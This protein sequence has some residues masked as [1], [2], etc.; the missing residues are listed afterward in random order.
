MMGASRDGAVLIFPAIQAHLLCAE[1]FP[2]VQ[3]SYEVRMCCVCLYSS[4]GQKI[5]SLHFA[6]CELSAASL[7]FR[8]CLSF[9]FFI[10][11]ETFTF[12]ISLF[13]Q[14]INLFHIHYVANK[15]IIIKTVLN[16]GNLRSLGNYSIHFIDS[17][18]FTA[19]M[20]FSCGLALH[21]I[22]SL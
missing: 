7:S 17:S 19:S 13:C 2:A 3:I 18:D 8:I 4:W 11:S 1:P 14:I 21:L 16:F 22:G 12:K 6:C 10:I 9:V 20:C 15:K 5:M